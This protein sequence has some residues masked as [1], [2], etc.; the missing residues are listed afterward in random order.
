MIK[1]ILS[2]FIFNLSLFAGTIEEINLDKR[3]NLL[4]NKVRNL[5]RQMIFL[6]ENLKRIDHNFEKIIY[7][8]NDNMYDRESRVKEVRDKNIV[9]MNGKIKEEKSVYEV[10]YDTYLYGDYEGKTI[11]ENIFIGEII[12]VEECPPCE[13]DS[14][15]LCKVRNK[16]AYIKVNSLK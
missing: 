13:K 14:N 16:N 2:F 12:D 9:K 10:V 6:N 15:C 3:T 1:I 7:L 8:M 4:E 11:I 5:E